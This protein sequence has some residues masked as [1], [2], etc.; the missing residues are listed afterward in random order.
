M[1]LGKTNLRGQHSWI[2]GLPVSSVVQ[3][4]F[5][6]LFCHPYHRTG[7]AGFLMCPKLLQRHMASVF[8]ITL[9]SQMVTRAP[10]IA[11]IFQTAGIQKKGYGRIKR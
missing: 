8:R 3:I 5:V 6:I 2:G 4:P 9:W 11:P 7:L 10:I 1:L